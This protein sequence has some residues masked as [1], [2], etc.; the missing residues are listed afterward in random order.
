MKGSALAIL[1]GMLQSPSGYKPFQLYPAILKAAIALM[2]P[3]FDHS[4]IYLLLYLLEE[5]YLFEHF[6]RRIPPALNSEENEI[7]LSGILDK[8]IGSTTEVWRLEVYQ[9]QTCDNVAQMS[10]LS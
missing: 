5:I 9:Y 2:Y 6:H 4:F 7:F 10:K 8:T 1:M 3:L